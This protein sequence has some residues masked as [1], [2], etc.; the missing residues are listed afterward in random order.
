MSNDIKK[1]KDMNWI[2]FG[3]VGLFII[4]S[5]ICYYF[6][7]QNMIFSGAIFGIK[8][9]LLDIQKQIPNF[10][11]SLIYPQTLEIIGDMHTFIQFLF[12]P[13]VGL[14]ACAIVILGCSIA[15]LVNSIRLIKRKQLKYGW[16]FLAISIMI[17]IL[18]VLFL[19]MSILG[20]IE[21]SGLSNI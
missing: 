17:I 5:L 7:Y 1:I 16:I 3:V 20:V 12:I 8:T 19:S 6:S 2:L 9:N 4:F 14:L 13:I 15:I 10:D 18:I 21:Q 11:E